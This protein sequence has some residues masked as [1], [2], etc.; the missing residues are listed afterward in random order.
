M[1]PKLGRTV[2]APPAHALH[3][4]ELE[5]GHPYTQAARLTQGGRSV[6]IN[7]CI[8]NHKFTNGSGS[9]A[10]TYAPIQARTQ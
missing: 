10:H 2:P 9:E 1:T 5:K 4:N 7:A 3:P 6:L 8:H